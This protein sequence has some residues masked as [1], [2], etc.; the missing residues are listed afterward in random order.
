MGLETFE[1]IDDLNQTFP[2]GSDDVSE[3]DDHLRGVKLTLK[4]T[5]PSNNGPGQFPNMD[6]FFRGLDLTGD[7]TIAGRIEANA[8]VAIALTTIGGDGDIT[9]PNEGVTAV[10]RIG[11]GEYE[12]QLQERD[13]TS[14]DDLAGAILVDYGLLGGGVPLLIAPSAN[15]I[16]QGWVRV[17]TLVNTANPVPSDPVDFSIV[18]FDIGRD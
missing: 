2:F 16:A 5:F 13:W 18:I 11:E 10:Q 7:A 8:Q 1:F 12:I 17:I 9:G 6:F 15:S 14:M 3:G 4:N